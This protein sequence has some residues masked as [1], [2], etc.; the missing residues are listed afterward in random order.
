M[1]WWWNINNNIHF[2]FGLFPGNIN[3]KNFQKIQ[4]TLFRAILGPFCPNLGKYESSWRKK[5][6]QFWN[7]PII[8]YCAKNQEHIM[9]NSWQKAKLTDRQTDRKW[10]FYRTLHRTGA[11]NVLLV[12]IYFSNILPSVFNTWFKLCSDI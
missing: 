4:N 6:C 2:H 1:D 8:Y 5:L 9:T 3:D 7:I 10:W 12:G 11:Q